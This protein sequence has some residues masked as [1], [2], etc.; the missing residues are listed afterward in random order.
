MIKSNFSRIDKR[1]LMI[2]A[3]RKKRK[4]RNRNLNSKR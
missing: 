1:K 4:G 3:I 2:S